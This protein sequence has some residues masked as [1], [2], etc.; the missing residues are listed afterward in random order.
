MSSLYITQV[1]KIKGHKIVVNDTVVFEDET[2]PDL[3]SFFKNAYKSL[4]YDY[5]KF[6]KM[7]HLSKLT[8]LATEPILQNE[9]DKNIALVFMNR[10]ASLDTDLKHQK[11]IQNKQEYYPSPA[12]FVYTLPNICLGEVSIK[13]KLQ[14]E[15]CF[16]V[17]E[18]FDAKLMYSYPEY[19]VQHKNV[20]KVLCGWIDV[21]EN[22]YNAVV[23]LVEKQGEKIHSR[24]ELDKLFI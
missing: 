11:S 2:A 18:N 20:N 13:H 7:D 12:V 10:A 21:L 23:Y 17:S 8:F 5:A 6:F 3:N 4:G 9:S 15:S 1:C 16:F 22:K 24:N 14:T 19:L